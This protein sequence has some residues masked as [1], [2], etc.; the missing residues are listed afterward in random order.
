MVRTGAFREDLLYRL[1]VVEIHIPPLRDRADD[2]P[3]L[4]EALL[5]KI[6]R[7]LHKP[8]RYV[9]PRAMALL[10]GYRW[11]G[12]VRELENMLTRAVVLAKSDV[13]EP[14]LLPIADEPAAAPASPVDD[15]RAVRPLRVVERLEIERALRAT[16][17]NKRRACALLEIS[18]PTLD[19]KID[20][21]G[22]RREGED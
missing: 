14:S 21:Y 17:W 19:R 8:M 1:K 16:A 18:R 15:E 9:A 4:V 7:E 5:G 10:T 12:N 3:L 11:P 2:I 20:E 22:L 13:L 6:G